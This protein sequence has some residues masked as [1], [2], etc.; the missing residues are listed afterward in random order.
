MRVCPGVQIWFTNLAL[1]TRY[2][3]CCATRVVASFLLRRLKS[4]SLFLFVF[5]C[6][7]A[8]FPTLKIRPFHRQA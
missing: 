3:I 5:L 4:L 8:F 1:K 6:Y 2:H 7:A